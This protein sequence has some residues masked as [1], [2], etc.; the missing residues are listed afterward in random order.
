MQKNKF[1][2]R[3]KTFLLDNMDI[4]VTL[5]GILP[6]IIPLFYLMPAK[7]DY[8]ILASAYE[9]KLAGKSCL[10]YMCDMV[11]ST[12]NNW[13]GIWFA[14]FLATGF[15]Y[16]FGFNVIF[17]RIG[18]LLIIICLTASMLYFLR[19]TTRYLDMD[20]IR[21]IFIPVVIIGALNTYSGDQAIYWF[22]SSLLYLFHFSLALFALSLFAEYLS[23]RKNLYLV[24][25]S[26]IAFVSTGGV[27]MVT[28]FLNI[29][30]LIMLC[31]LL[32]V[33]RLKKPQMFFFLSCIAGALINALAPGNFVRHARIIEIQGDSVSDHSTVSL[34]MNACINTIKIL[35]SCYGKLF[36]ISFILVVI[37]SCFFMGV[38]LRNK[39]KMN[40]FAVIF[41]GVAIVFV[42]IF[43]I[44][45][46]Y[47][48]SIIDTRSQY[49]IGMVEMLVAS[50]I[51]Y[52][53][54]VWISRKYDITI[55]KNSKII[56]CAFLLCMTAGNVVDNYKSD[57]SMTSITILKEA[58]SGTLADYEESYRKIYD[59]IKN[60]DSDDVVMQIPVINTKSLVPNNVSWNGA[61]GYLKEFIDVFEY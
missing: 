29:C 49:L 46:G 35:V 5:I 30:A 7:D 27:L 36:C 3:M 9:Y 2:E 17:Y 60:D 48:S 59:S 8:S 33:H 11:K 1:C 47:N 25:S 20:K 52:A 41:G 32:Y 51:F 15:I 53:L 26:V 45:Y 42:T 38:A 16:Y 4:F 13:Q 58:G 12:Y 44:A 19:V 43:P 37:C 21:Y 23:N 61:L 56:I 22:C 55:D 28:G 40:I 6:L 50:I 34:L 39:R 14:Q 18:I 54:G 24:I 31:Y 10:E 57:E